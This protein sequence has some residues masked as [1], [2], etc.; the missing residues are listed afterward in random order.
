MHEVH[1]IGQKK[2]QTNVTALLLDYHPRVDRKS[3][4]LMAKAIAFLKSFKD[5]SGSKADVYDAKVR[6]FLPVTVQNK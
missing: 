5:S 3:G 4:W 1:W 2:D 6:R